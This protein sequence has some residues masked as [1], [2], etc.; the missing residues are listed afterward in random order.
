MARPPHT[1]STWS[2]LAGR[3]VAGLIG[4]VRR[5]SRIVYDPPDALER[6][7]AQHPVI[8]AVWHGQFMMTSGFRPAPHVKVAAMVARHG[9]A[10]FIGTAM[11]HLGVELIRGAGAGG[12]RKDR[13]GAYALRQAVR[14]LERG[15][16]ARDDR[17]RA[18]RAR[19]ARWHRHRHARAP[20][21]PPDRS[22]RI[23]HDALHRARHLEPDD[24]Q[25]AVLQARVRGRR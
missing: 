6:L 23:R 21:R 7:E 20:F 14:A 2:W 3:A 16:L 8:V 19:A 11:A 25:P 5:T 22:R 17:R 4:L 18:A 12:R 13:G 9:D 10:E 24:D 1:T 15:R